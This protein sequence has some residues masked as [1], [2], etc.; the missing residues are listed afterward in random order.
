[1]GYTNPNY[2]IFEIALSLEDSAPHTGGTKERKLAGDIVAIRRPAQAIG[3]KEA[4]T[5]LWLRVQG[6]EENNMA[7]LT[8]SIE[9]FDK[10]RY[11][12]PLERLKEIVP[13]FDITKALDPNVTYQPFLILDEEDYR[14]L[15]S[16][17]PFEIED[18][19]FDKQTGKYGFS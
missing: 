13:T 17:Q 11:C 2:P 1:M 16:E 4:K 14:F 7:R 3:I 19:L 6:L 12:I 9:G 5:Y 18:I 15:G 8:D 10:R